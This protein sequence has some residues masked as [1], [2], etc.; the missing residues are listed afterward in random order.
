M[1]SST[2]SAR[3]AAG[4][5]ATASKRAA[6]A[7]G[8]SAPASSAK[9]CTWRALVT[10]M[11][12]GSTGLVTPALG[13]LVD[14]GQVRLGLEEELG[15]GEVGQLQLGGQEVAVAAAVT[16]RAR[17]QLGV[18]GHPDAEVARVAARSR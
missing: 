16:V 9:R 5:S 10:G 14:H 4:S 8:N 7:G 1:A 2:P 11:M 15:D 12:P 17:V 13:Q 6:S 18:G 3:T